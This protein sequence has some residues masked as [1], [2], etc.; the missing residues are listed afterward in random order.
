MKKVKEIERPLSISDLATNHLREAIINGQLKLGEAISELTIAQSLKVSKTP[1]RHALAQ[2]KVEGLV[3]VVPQKGTFVFTLSTADLRAFCEH[4]L[5]LESSALRLS[6][7]RNLQR[8]CKDLQ[9]V[10]KNMAKSRKKKSSAEYIRLDVD[11]HDMF[12]KHAD[13][14]YIC[15]S[16]ALISA[17][18]AALRT[19]LASWPRQTEQSYREHIKI[20]EVL[21]DSNLT[22]AI[23]TLS[24]HIGRYTRTYTKDTDNIAAFDE[25]INGLN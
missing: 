17:K 11:F 25:K 12:F 15:E 8:L 4:R 1:V 3:T 14:K 2:M 5:I 19:H 7:E 20:I 6:Y 23:D 9:A 13:N 10:V 16:Y 18:A 24:H 22:L 21:Q